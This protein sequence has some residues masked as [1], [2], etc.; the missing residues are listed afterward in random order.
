MEE[1]KL[2][3][4]DGEP[5]FVVERVNVL[6]ILTSAFKSFWMADRSDIGA[7]KMVGVQVNTTLNGK[8]SDVQ[9]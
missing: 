8:A 3:Q 6:L 1:R 2:S 5:I 9:T 7:V 4:S